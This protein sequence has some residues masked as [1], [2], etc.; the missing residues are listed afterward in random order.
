MAALILLRYRQRRLLRRNRIFR[1]R[2]NP[3][4]RFDDLELFRKFRFRRADI[5]QMTD[6]LK[7]QLEHPNRKGA[8]PPV[9][10]VLLTLRFYAS[11]SFQ[12]ICA[13]LIGVDQSTASR[14]IQR[15]TE[16][17][18]DWV[19]QW[20]RFP[21]QHEAERTKE[22]FFRM[23]RFPNVVGC[24]DGTQIRIQ[25]PQEYEHEYV[26]RKNYHSINVQVSTPSDR[27][28]NYKVLTIT[29]IRFEYTQQQHTKCSATHTRSNMHIHTEW[30]IIIIIIY[31]YLFYYYYFF[32]G[33]GG[34]GGGIG[35]R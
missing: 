24:I 20:I 8:L 10:Q 26:N 7:D 18:M 13:E 11:G 32:F 28:T 33:G 6:E 15:V 4:D 3:L 5:L 12:D 22:M 16:A 1:D 31:F 30:I 27:S 23:N 25:A 17:F 34:G 29:W 35:L 2:T 21:N 19:P 14:A 9:L